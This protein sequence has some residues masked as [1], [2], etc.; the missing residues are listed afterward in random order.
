MTDNAN[1]AAKADKVR[2]PPPAL[3]PESPAL[4]QP[5]KDFVSRGFVSSLTVKYSP[6]G[7]QVFCAVQESLKKP[8]DPS[9]G[10]IALGDA[11]NRIVEAKLWAPKAQNKAKTDKNEV[12]RPKKSLVKEDFE[13]S[14]ADLLTRADAIA[15]ATGS[16][17]A[18]GRIGSLKMFIDGATTF[19]AWWDEASPKEKTRLFSDKKHHDEFTEEMHLQF[20]RCVSKCPFLGPVPDPSQEKEEDE[21]PEKPTEPAVE[22]P[23]G[24]LVK[25]QRK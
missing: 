17:T 5:W 1:R 21:E 12:A 6:L 20:E 3:N 10:E 14:D 4:T 16:T 7:V 2:P 8:D 22:K 23:S 13:G 19:E 24:T 11:K 15:K 25:K 9:N 18:K